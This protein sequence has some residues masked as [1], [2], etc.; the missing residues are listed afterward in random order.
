MIINLTLGEFLQQHTCYVMDLCSGQVCHTRKFGHAC[1][2]SVGLRWTSSAF[3]FIF[4]PELTPPAVH[5]S[6]SLNWNS[7]PK[8]ESA[9][10]IFPCHE[11]LFSD[12]RASPD[13]HVWLEAHACP[14]YPSK[15]F[16]ISLFNNTGIT[17][18]CV[19][20][21][22]FIN[23]KNIFY[24]TQMVYRNIVEFLCH[25]QYLHLVN[26]WLKFVFIEV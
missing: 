2:V 5:T 16:T 14:N 3:F 21:F 25:K 9:R 15:L 23:S 1:L 17:L 10:T 20:I 24:E 12:S 19:V 4:F 7:G 11:T 18:P 8:H 22:G 6:S 26:L 13:T